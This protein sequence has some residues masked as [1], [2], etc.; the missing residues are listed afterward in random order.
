MAF[1]EPEMWP[2]LA[3]AFFSGLVLCWLIVGLWSGLRHRRAVRSW[4]QRYSVVESSLNKSIDRVR[5]AEAALTETRERANRLQAELSAGR[6]KQADVQKALKTAQSKADA[7][8]SERRQAMRLQ[9]ES[10]ERLANL[11]QEMDLLRTQA[12]ALEADKLALT[13]NLHEQAASI[14]RVSEELDARTKA[15][16]TTRY[17]LTRQHARISE[18]GKQLDNSES[19]RTRDAQAFATL[20]DAKQI[21]D[22]RIERLTSQLHDNDIELNQLRNRLEER[23]EAFA[24]SQQELFGARKRVPQLERLLIDRDEALRKLGAQIRERDI[25][26]QRRDERGARESSASPRPRTGDHRADETAY[27]LFS[28]AGEPDDLKRIKGIGPKL[29]ALLNS[30]G[31]YQFGQIATFSDSDIRRI[32]QELSGFKKR[33]TDDD[34]IDQASQLQRS[35]ERARRQD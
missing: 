24:Q 12:D 33:I 31:I 5:D 29:E 15:L 16:S 2:Y 7:V 13:K 14:D 32:S 4:S 20:R 8:E 25:L 27:P 30:I 21:D 11:A 22:H 10:A 26:L 23:D 3:T 1:P 9:E 18:L 28:P 34:W 6:S 19:E 35:T 17:E